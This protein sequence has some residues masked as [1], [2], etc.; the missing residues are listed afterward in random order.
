MS[1]EIVE[2]EYNRLIK[3][4]A[5]GA[6]ILA[7]FAPGADSVNAG[8]PRELWI[9]VSQIAG[10]APAVPFTNNA[11]RLRVTAWIAKEKGIAAVPE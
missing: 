5:S 1:I 10:K 7:E 4:S 2:I 6:A 11:G 3:Y 9:P 8:E